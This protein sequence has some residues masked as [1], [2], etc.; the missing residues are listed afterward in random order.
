[1]SKPTSGNPA[2]G[3]KNVGLP[4]DLNAKL[5]LLMRY[6][7]RSKIDQIKF[8]INAAYDAMQ[9]EIE[10]KEKRGKGL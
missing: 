3:R 1:M 10:R 8:F 6:H 7:T 2:D 5:E 4:P 9:A